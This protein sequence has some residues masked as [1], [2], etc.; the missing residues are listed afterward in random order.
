MI[1]ERECGVNPTFLPGLRIH[2]QQANPTNA[3]GSASWRGSSRGL[4]LSLCRTASSEPVMRV[5][6]GVGKKGNCGCP[7]KPWK[8]RTELKLS[9]VSMVFPD[10]EYVSGSTMVCPDP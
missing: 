7:V 3:A 8:F 6:V 1:R 10:I 5:G 4:A 9:E 2:N